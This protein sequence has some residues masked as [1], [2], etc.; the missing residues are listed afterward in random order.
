M[1]WTGGSHPPAGGRPGPRS[2]ALKTLPLLH[3]GGPANSTGERN[4][5]LGQA[6]AESTG[7]HGHH[8]CRARTQVYSICSSCS[9]TSIVVLGP[10]A[11]R[12]ARQHEDARYRRA[13]G[14]P[15]RNVNAFFPGWAGESEER[16]SFRGSNS[17]TARGVVRQWCEATVYTAPSATRVTT[18]VKQRGQDRQDKRRPSE[19]TLWV[20][21]STVR[22]T[23]CPFLT[24]PYHWLHQWGL[25]AAW[26]K[27]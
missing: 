2:L 3:G 9:E 18:E 8:Q 10:E 22:P 13:L 12:G 27:P 7:S 20:R 17:G 6:D 11:R 5:P 26:R 15:H 19:S 25:G 14:T 24:G 1:A 16:S 21:S 23:A 4:A